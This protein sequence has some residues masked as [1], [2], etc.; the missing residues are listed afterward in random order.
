MPNLPSRVCLRPLM[1]AHVI[2][3]K[4]KQRTCTTTYVAFV[5]VINKKKYAVGINVWYETPWKSEI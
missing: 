3:C 1:T 5:S 2:G 4:L